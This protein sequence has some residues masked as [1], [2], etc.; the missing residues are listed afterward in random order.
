MRNISPYMM[1]RD[2]DTSLENG[3]GVFVYL[4]TSGVCIVKVSGVCIVKVSGVCIVKV[5]LASRNYMC[6]GHH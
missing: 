4:I 3:L 6:T 2:V 5:M 1:H